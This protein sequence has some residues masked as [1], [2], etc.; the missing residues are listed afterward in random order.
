[1][2]LPLAG[3]GWLDTSAL[4]DAGLAA[5]AA[6]RTR[7]RGEGSG[8]GKEGTQPQ[9]NESAVVAL[10]RQVAS[11]ARQAVGG[12]VDVVTLAV[13]AGWSSRRAAALRDACQRAGLGVGKLVTAPVA[14]GWHL[15]AGGVQLPAGASVLV[16]QVGQDDCTATVLRRTETGFEG[17]SSVDS[18]TVA[19]GMAGP[20]ADVLDAH[21]VIGAGVSVG[22]VAVRAVVGAQ[23]PLG[24]LGLVCAVGS[25]ADSPQ[26]AEDLARATGV[27]PKVV[28]EADLAVVLGAVQAPTSAPVV[29]AAP[30]VGW[31]DLMAA[32]VPVVWSVVLFWQVLAGGER[33]G[34]REKVFDRGMVLAAWG[35][36]AVAAQLGMVAVVGGLAVTTALRGGAGEAGGGGTALVG[37]VRHRLLALALVGGAAG[38]LLVAAVFAMI[39][40]GYFDLDVGPLLRWSVLPVLPTAVVVM[41]LALVVWRRPEPPGGSWLTWLRFPPAV[42]M[43]AGAG[44]LLVSFDEHGS[45]LVLNLLAWQLEQWFP[46]TGVEIIGPVGRL[47]GACIGAAVGLLVV[48]RVL[49]RLLV[50]VPLALLV[51]GTLVWRITGTVAVGF[52]LAVAG[53]WAAR[54]AWLLLRP[55]LLTPPPEPAEQP[56]PSN[57][58]QPGWANDGSGS[59][60]PSHGAGGGW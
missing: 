16:C 29:D 22:D 14:V 42:T 28:A 3:V 35:G 10:F 40:A 17:L 38:G 32:M 7:V 59:G 58:G 12:D 57:V 6:A 37:W 56:H 46:T 4:A 31:L 48:R 13:P 34:L 27:A 26:V 50:A 2:V 1:M 45:P 52:S 55:K 43:L 18:S 33:Y 36:L 51:A 39:A 8:R 24:S 19:A 23:L 47:G 20:G 11:A 49:H 44:A 41:I 54:T 30:E 21:G 15:L 60:L 9:P 5:A 25:V 53:W